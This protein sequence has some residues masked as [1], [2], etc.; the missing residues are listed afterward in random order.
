M[1]IIHLSQNVGR[2]PF[3]STTQQ[4]STRDTQPSGSNSVQNPNHRMEKSPAQEVYENEYVP[5][6]SQAHSKI[7][8]YI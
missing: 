6:T 2:H 8:F 3:N 5:K 7:F 4:R 1:Y